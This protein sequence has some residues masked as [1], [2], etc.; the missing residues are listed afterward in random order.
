MVWLEGDEPAR[1]DFKAA[2]GR[3]HGGALAVGVVQAALVVAG[4][5]QAGVDEMNRPA[6]QFGPVVAQ[7]GVV[8]FDHTRHVGADAGIA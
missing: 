8:A 3:C 1:P 7:T 2:P 6:F 4:L 5:V